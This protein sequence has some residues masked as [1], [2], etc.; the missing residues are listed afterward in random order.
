[1]FV[2]VDVCRKSYFFFLVQSFI[3]LYVTTPAITANT[4]GHDTDMANTPKI[5]IAKIHSNNVVTIPSPPIIRLEKV[6]DM[7]SPTPGLLQH[8]YQYQTSQNAEI[9]GYC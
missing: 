8:K 1:M 6:E 5:R 4:T 2:K 3:N 9:S 7:K